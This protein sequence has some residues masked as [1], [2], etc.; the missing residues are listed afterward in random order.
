MS[1]F[2]GVNNID[3]YRQFNFRL[4]YSVNAIAYPYPKP[5]NNFL[6]GELSYYGKINQD[7]ESI[8]PKKNKLVAL[9]NGD[10][11]NIF[12]VFDFVASQFSLFRET[13]KKSMLTG[14]INKQDQ[15]LS[16]ITPFKSYE[17]VNNLYEIY[18]DKINTFFINYIIENKQENNIKTIQQ[19][20]DYYEKFCVEMTKNAPIT[21]GKFIKSKFC[22]MTISGLVIEIAN[23]DYSIDQAKYDL[24]I[25]SSNFNFYRNAAI[26][27]GFSI[28]LNAP[29]RLIADI[30]SPPMLQALK[31]K[32]IHSTTSFFQN[33]YDISTNNEI[34]IIKTNLY[35][36][37]N[38]F[39]KLRPIIVE[40]YDCNG[41]T[42]KEVFNR[43]IQNLT[44]YNKFMD[45]TKLL[46]IYLKIRN[47]ELENKFTDGEINKI[48]K[49]AMFKNKV[50]DNKKFSSYLNTV[51]LNKELR[52]SGTINFL[53]KKQK[54]LDS[55]K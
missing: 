42:K 54:V 31:S 26:A 51:F 4:N 16:N 23:L 21:K 30:N 46:Q 36:L 37:Y 17:D 1:N 12:F 47:N 22:P 24:F 38:K 53:I 15:F 20:I 52:E 39:V 55:E 14:R 48:L 18:L 6:F 50:L 29:W 44:T 13:F 28:D 2:F 10:D 34:E 5:I 33:Y 40:T 32:S 35:S 19:F 7:Y 25:N 49:E 43:E 27:H 41:L 8:I 11:S 9:S 3:S 45:N